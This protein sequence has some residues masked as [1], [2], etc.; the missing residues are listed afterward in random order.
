VTARRRLVYLADVVGR[1]V[2]T[3]D[4]RVVGRIEE[5]RT[6][7][8]ANGEHEVAEYHLGSGALLERLA[9]V[10]SLVTPKRMLIARWDQIDIRR[11]EAPLLTCAVEELRGASR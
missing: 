6:A 1:R 7:R 5:V 8:R 11:P 4:G 10:R 3:A 2:R 9:V